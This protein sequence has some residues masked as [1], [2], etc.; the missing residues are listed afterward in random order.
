LAPIVQGVTED[1]PAID[2]L[3]IGDDGN[4]IGKF[5]QRTTSTFDGDVDEIR[6]WNRVLSPEEIRASYDANS[7]RLR[8]RFPAAQGTKADWSIIGANAADQTIAD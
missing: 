6:V 8:A 3:R 2:G 7:N 1:I 4:F 5:I